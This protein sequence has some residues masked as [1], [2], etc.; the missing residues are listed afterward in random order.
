M[1]QGSNG[2]VVL[3]PIVSPYSPTLSPTLKP[4]VTPT[5]PPTSAPTFGGS[6]ASIIYSYTGGAQT[7]TIPIGIGTI[8]V[9]VLGAAGSSFN[10]QAYGGYASGS[11]DVTSGEIINIFVGGIGGSYYTP[12][13]GA[14]GYNG[15]GAGFYGGGGGGTDIRYCKLY[16]NVYC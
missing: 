1:P 15:G 11:F 6:A 8:N 9:E 2:K 16:V 14:G 10:C 5:I 7:Y 3:T 12:T 13:N 4:S